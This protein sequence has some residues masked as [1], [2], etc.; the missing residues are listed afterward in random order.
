MLGALEALGRL[1]TAV[2]SAPG[3]EK[4]NATHPRCAIAT[5]SFAFDIHDASGLCFRLLWRGTP[6]PSLRDVSRIANSEAVVFL[7]DDFGMA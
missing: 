6:R 2:E 4:S 3:L 5:A 7:F 1:A